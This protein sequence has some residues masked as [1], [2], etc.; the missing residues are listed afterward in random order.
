MIYFILY[1]HP[2]LVIESPIRVAKNKSETQ[3][4]EL[5]AGSKMYLNHVKKV[6][7]IK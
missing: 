5:Q 7:P 2:C 6:L 4:H 3:L 1:H